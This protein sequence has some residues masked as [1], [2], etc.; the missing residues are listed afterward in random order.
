MEN[1]GMHPLCDV[2]RKA[3]HFTEDCTKPLRENTATLRLLLETFN[4]IEQ[5]RSIYNDVTE[6]I[7]ECTRIEKE[8][9]NLL[10]QRT[11]DQ[12]E[13]DHRLGNAVQVVLFAQVAAARV[14]KAAAI[15]RA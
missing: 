15:R 9:S 1:L 5:R 4:E 8:V 7:Y 12:D 2:C 13:A 6:A 10:E 14:M 11:I 3:G